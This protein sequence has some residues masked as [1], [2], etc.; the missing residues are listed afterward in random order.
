[1]CRPSQPA[2]IGAG[3]QSVT[4]KKNLL[5]PFEVRERGKW[6]LK[7]PPDDFSAKWIGSY[8]FSFIQLISAQPIATELAVN[9]QRICQ[10]NECEWKWVAH[11]LCDASRLS[12]CDANDGVYVR[13]M[14]LMNKT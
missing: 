12:V 7:H 6:H 2:W 1:M 10:R 3:L 9:E 4:M 5:T 11:F 13:K 8:F 14:I